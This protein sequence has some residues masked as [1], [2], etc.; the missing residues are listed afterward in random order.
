VYVYEPVRL[1]FHANLQVA[2]GDEEVVAYADSLVSPDASKAKA[3]FLQAMDRVVRLQLEGTAGSLTHHTFAITEVHV[4]SNPALR[5]AGLL[6]LLSPPPPPPSPAGRRLS[7]SSEEEEE[8]VGV[9]HPEAWLVY[10]TTRAVST[11]PFFDGTKDAGVTHCQGYVQA[12]LSVVV[13]VG[14]AAAAL[15]STCVRI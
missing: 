1:D 10:S 4:Y 12:A 2:L 7:Q 5:L 13:K 9:V 11:V 8:G 15:L 6:P 3:L 14:C